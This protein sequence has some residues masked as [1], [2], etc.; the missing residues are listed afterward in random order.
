MSRKIIFDRLKRYQW[1]CDFWI[2]K[3]DGVKWSGKISYDPA[4]GLQCE[5]FVPDNSDELEKSKTIHGKSFDIGMFSLTGCIYK[6]SISNSHYVKVNIAAS[7]MVLGEAPKDRNIYSGASFDIN[8]LKDFCR[9]EG[10]HKASLGFQKIILS[11][12]YRNFDLSIMKLTTG[13]WTDAKTITNELVLQSSDDSADLVQIEE[14]INRDV[15]KILDEKNV[16]LF[17]KGEVSYRLFLKSRSSNIDAHD[18]C[19]HVHNVAQ[20]FSLL[21]VR[22]CLA[23][24]VKLMCRDNRLPEDV[25]EVERPVLISTCLSKYQLDEVS[26]GEWNPFTGIAVKDIGGNFQNV[27][28]MWIDMIDSPLDL[29]RNVIFEYIGNSYNAAQHAVVCISAL[30]QWY[31]E[32]GDKSLP[33]YDYMINKYL[34]EELRSKLEA[35]IPIQYSKDKTLG[36]KLSDIRGIILHPNSARKYKYK[37]G[38]AI[39]EVCLLNISEVII[40]SLLRAVFDKFGIDHKGKFNEVLQEHFLV[41][42]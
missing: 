38:K 35:F 9:S 4:N 37:S 21:M 1:L 30:E 5:I 36:E 19:V 3:N 2:P 16:H 22:P 26:K 33:K 10:K 15:A 18:L 34:T 31:H 17:K 6:N 11:A 28:H 39:D 41:E 24:D 13:Y 25:R 32:N 40:V 14:D 27:V 20:M 7:Y 29:I 12:K 8:H 23:L 42:H